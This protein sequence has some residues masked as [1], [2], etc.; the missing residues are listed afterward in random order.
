MV[1]KHYQLMNHRSKVEGIDRED[2]DMRDM[3]IKVKV[4]EREYES[5]VLA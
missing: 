3:T 4:V 1:E 5:V 2:S